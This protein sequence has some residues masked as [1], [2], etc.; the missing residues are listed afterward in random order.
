MYYYTEKEA[1]NSKMTLDGYN[2]DN[3]FLTAKY[4][5][6][7]DAENIDSRT[8]I[9]G[10]LPFD[11]EA[12]HVVEIFSN[13]GS[14]MKVEMP[15]E[16]SKSKN[17]KIYDDLLSNNNNSEKNLETI[18]S[19]SD[20]YIKEFIESNSKT[21]KSKLYFFYQYKK[22]KEILSQIGKL[23]NKEMNTKVAESLK[24]LY[25]KFKFYVQKIFPK[26]IINSLIYNEI[27]KNNDNVDTLDSY[28]E[29]NKEKLAE[30]Y[31]KIYINM[32]S[33]IS[34]YDDKV[35]LL[36]QGL[37]EDMVPVDISEKEYKNLNPESKIFFIQNYIIHTLKRLLMKKILEF[38]KLT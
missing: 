37:T 6:D 29:L 23:T 21:K 36:A 5:K 22:V 11:I 2:F 33:L 30:A 38:S 24:S 27:I 17:K 34:K 35:K 32:S 26:E 3:F 4:Y 10:N 9:V 16:E 31:N 25:Q 20:N 7:Y 19:Y 15:I 1:Y 28:E 12:Q 14:V 8:L 13:H 18:F